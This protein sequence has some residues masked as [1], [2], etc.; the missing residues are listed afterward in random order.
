LHNILIYLRDEFEFVPDD[1]ADD[2][3]VDVIKTDAQESP[4]GK[5]FQNA[6]RDSWLQGVHARV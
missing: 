3:G 6:V 2:D 5:N 4:Q 1:V